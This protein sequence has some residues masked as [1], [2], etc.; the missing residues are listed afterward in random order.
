MIVT[1]TVT[2]DVPLFTHLIPII[3]SS[4]L[5]VVIVV[6]EAELFDIDDL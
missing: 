6:G 2:A 3:A 4:E 1:V 5:D